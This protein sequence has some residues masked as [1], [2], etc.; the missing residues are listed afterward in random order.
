L[1]N[2]LIL[3]ELLKIIKIGGAMA[4]YYQIALALLLVSTSFIAYPRFSP[5]RSIFSSLLKKVPYQKAGAS[6]IKSHNMRCLI[7]GSAGVTAS[8]VL[9]NY[10][11][12]QE[13]D[14]KENRVLSTRHA[15][16]RN[17]FN[18][19][20][21]TYLSFLECKKKLPYLTDTISEEE[22]LTPYGMPIGEARKRIQQ[23]IKKHYIA[24]VSLRKIDD[25]IGFGVFAEQDIQEGEI[26]AEY[27]GKVQSLSKLPTIDLS[28]DMEAFELTESEKKEYKRIKNIYDFATNYA[29]KY[30]IDAHDC[31]NLSRFINH[32][33]LPNVEAV[34]IPQGGLFHVVFIAGKSIKKGEQLFINYGIGYWHGRAIEPLE[35]PR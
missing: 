34:G 20:G 2:F 32:S 1:L 22:L 30:F 5:K 26:I 11:I 28:R 21:L 33:F 7:G 16:W 19:L 12:R 10:Q 17:T 31:G 6:F 24:N 35:L 18:E 27:T 23:K 15:Q 13:N 4:N 14:T 3:I 29:G 9:K 8:Y 25:V